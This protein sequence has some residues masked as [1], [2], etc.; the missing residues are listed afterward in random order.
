MSETRLRG[1]Q[2]S[3]LFAN[4]RSIQTKQGAAAEDV[5][6]TVFLS[7][8]HNDRPLIQPAIGFLKQHGVRI[9]V[10]WLDE[11]M[12]ITV[13]DETATKLKKKI[14]EHRKFIV[15]ATR[16]SKDSKWVPWELGYADR[17]KTIEH[18]AI[19]PI[20]ELDG[21]NFDGT[22]YVS[23]YPKIIEHEQNKFV[24]WCSKPTK[25]QTLPE[26]LRQ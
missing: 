26:W 11:D 24:V 3:T 25:W 21:W 1:F 23:I 4:E 9:Y 19:L 16:N 22:E 12:P 20:A 6:T 18:L 8:S 2:P 7:H 10:D 17:T 14:E 13:N 5:E 15:L